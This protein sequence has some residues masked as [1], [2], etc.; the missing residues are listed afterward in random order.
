VNANRRRKHHST[1]ARC[2]AAARF[3][4]RAVACMRAV[5]G[6]K[7]GDSNHPPHA[8]KR[9][10]PVIC[11]QLN[12]S[13]PRIVRLAK[14]IGRENVMAHCRFAQSPFARLRPTGHHVGEAESL[15]EG[16]RIATRVCYGASRPAL[17]M[18]LTGLG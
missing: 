10:P 1:L 18:R 3:Q 5:Y 17:S 15:V 9:N 11:P 4:R 7:S 14:I 13:S 12:C 2:V 6:H 8:I 16:A